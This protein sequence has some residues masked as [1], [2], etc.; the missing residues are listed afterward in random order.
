MF[1]GADTE[2]LRQQ[3]TLLRNRSSS[4]EDLLSALRDTANS[5]EWEGTDAERFRTEVDQVVGSQGLPLAA[6][7]EALS[8][9][10]ER[11]ADEQD[12]TSE[13]D[14][15]GGGGF[16]GIPGLPGIPGFPGGPQIPGLPGLPGGPGIPGF[17]GGPG[18][19]GLPGGPD[20]PEFR[21]PFELDD[22]PSKGFWGD[23]LGEKAGPW[24]NLI[25]N[26]ASTIGGLA[27][28]TP[29]VGAPV[30]I[31]IDAANMGISAYDMSQ[32]FRDGDPFKMIDSTITFG[33]STAD[34]VAN[35]VELGGTPA[36]PVG[37]VGA[38]ASEI[39]GALSAGWG[40]LST[41]AAGA[42]LM[43]VEGDG[44]VS[45]TLFNMPTTINDHVWQPLGDHIGGPV[46]NA[47]GTA[48]NVSAAAQQSAES[49]IDNG[50]GSVTDYA[51]DHVPGLDEALAAPRRLV[52][53]PRHI[54]E[55][56]I[57]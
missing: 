6:R 45:R 12:E 2:Q 37:W 19:P 33:L 8:H 9:E 57:P 3:G 14:G 50:F 26:G 43:G 39:T 55:D 20:L 23:L 42:D 11:Q 38:G 22:G 48:G 31:G 1:L 16:P 7:I 35:A 4:L 36:T 51:L 25:W 30:A 44:S 13:A 27:S 17:P 52:E 54:I 15:G 53:A 46:G 29:W 41:G 21:N 56:L 32:A 49:M 24:G 10:L 18:I 5:V 34:L 47:I 28:M 40:M